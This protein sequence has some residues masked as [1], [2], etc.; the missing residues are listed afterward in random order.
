MG[1][2][3]KWLAILGRLSNQYADQRLQELN[4]NSSHLAFLI[5]INNNP[6]ITQDRLK[7]M[8]YVHPSNITRA[9]D[10]LE[11]EG[12]ITKET[13]TSD[14]RTN[15]IYPTEKANR[16][17]EYIVKVAVEW[18]S[19]ITANMSQ[20]QSEEFS[21]LLDLAGNTSIKYWLDN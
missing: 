12:Y 21:K 13:L 19:I 14:K 11:K 15:K 18:E 4:I 6:G 8:I 3:F 7:T 2:M 10:Y 1:Q 5:N 9:L 16:V 20:E 17:H